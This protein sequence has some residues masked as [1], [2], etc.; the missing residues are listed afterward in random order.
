M[1]GGDVLRRWFNEN[2]RKG[3][4]YARELND[5]E[6]AVVREL[7]A[8][9]NARLADRFDLNLAEYHYPLP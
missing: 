3:P 8:E 4:S 1:P 2:L 5:A 6:R 9:G 7:F